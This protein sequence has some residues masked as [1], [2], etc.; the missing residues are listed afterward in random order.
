MKVLKLKTKLKTT[1][2]VLLMSFLIPKGS[3]AKTDLETMLFRAVTTNDANLVENAI[4]EGADPNALKPMFNDD[5]VPPLFVAIDYGYKNI[6]SIL[7][8]N[9]ADPNYRTNTLNRT[10]LMHA[11]LNGYKS[12][13]YVGIVD[14]LLKAGAD[15]NKQ[16]RYSNNTALI[17]LIK[18]VRFGDHYEGFE[19]ILEL[20]I[21]AGANLDIQNRVTDAPN[22]TALMYAAD[23]YTRDMRF[24]INTLLKAGANPYIQDDEGETAL[25][26][27]MSNIRIL[28]QLSVFYWTIKNKLEKGEY[29]L[30][31]KLTTAA[32]YGYTKTVI[33]LMNSG[34]DPNTPD[35]AGQLPLVLAVTQRNE[36]MV[37]YLLLNGADPILMDKDGKTAMSVA[38]DTYQKDIMEQLQ[39]AL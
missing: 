23:G 36:D 4:A 7:L 35:K 9:G 15:P 13:D 1:V 37:Y 29:S 8:E 16:D 25:D 20:L 28:P 10:L 11:M 38:K 12:P 19:E 32:Y 14:M 27:W 31:T 5:N 6:V 22:R 33:D 39:S 18:E 17:L 3:L 24:I 2:L 26:I 21:S 34:L 30:W